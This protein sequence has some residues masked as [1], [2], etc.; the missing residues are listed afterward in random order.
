MY[1]LFKTENGL[2]AYTRI[3]FSQGLQEKSGFRIW[4]F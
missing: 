4:G 1:L 2:L 3:A